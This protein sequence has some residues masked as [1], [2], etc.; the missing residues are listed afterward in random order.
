MRD[1]D[2]RV[3]PI[4]HRLK[5]EIYQL[6]DYLDSKSQLLFCY[7]LVEQYSLQAA[8]C[9]VAY[10]GLLSRLVI[11][12]LIQLMFRQMHLKNFLRYL[13]RTTRQSFQ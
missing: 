9:L 5:H 2:I 12:T 4:N 6:R 11:P 13:I 7:P 8:H 10:P 3:F 1:F